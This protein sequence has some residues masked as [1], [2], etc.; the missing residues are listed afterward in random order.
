MR[1]E[2]IFELFAGF[3]WII[4]GFGLAD[5]CPPQCVIDYFKKKKK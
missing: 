5:L 4:T 1:K 2:M 3:F